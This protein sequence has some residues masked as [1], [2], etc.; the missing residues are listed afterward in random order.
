LVASKQ[1][2]GTPWRDETHERI[3]SHRRL[4]P[5]DRSTDFR[6]GLK[7]LKA[8]SKPAALSRVTPTPLLGAA[9][10]DTRWRGDGA[11]LDGRR[12]RP[13]TT[14]ARRGRGG[15]ETSP[16]IGRETL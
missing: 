12:V 1:R 3:G 4:I 6:I 15:R 8:R 10:D 7:P 16:A 9:M 2:G 14:N 5:A 11:S 13:S